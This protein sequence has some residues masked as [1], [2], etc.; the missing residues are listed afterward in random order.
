MADAQCMLGSNYNFGWGVEQDY[1]QAAQ[2]YRKA[3]E[4]GY[5]EAQFNL[6]LC[7][8]YGKGVEQD[9]TQAVYWFR[10]AAEQGL[11]YAIEELKELGY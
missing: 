6:G 4:Q 9:Y 5:A 3:A 2:W 1:K 7:Y 11:A 8:E 10:K